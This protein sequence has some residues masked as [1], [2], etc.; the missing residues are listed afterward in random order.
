[1]KTV[2]K[3]IWKMIGSQAGQVYQ[4]R[5]SLRLSSYMVWNA[6]GLYSLNITT[7]LKSNSSNHYTFN[8]IIE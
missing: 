3:M 6:L 4:L 5:R 7:N 2:V 8:D 1:M